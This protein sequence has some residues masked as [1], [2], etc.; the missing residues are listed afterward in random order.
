M[1][2]FYLF[3]D[4]TNLRGMRTFVNFSLDRLFSRLA[5][6][7]QPVN[8]LTPKINAFVSSYVW[9]SSFPDTFYTVNSEL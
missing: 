4:P 7:L 5:L 1:F 2:V 9:V 3:L 6:I 8:G